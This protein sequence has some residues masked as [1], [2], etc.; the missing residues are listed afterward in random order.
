MDVEVINH[1]K[2]KIIQWDKNRYEKTGLLGSKSIHHRLML[3]A[4]ILKINETICMN[5]AF[6]K[7]IELVKALGYKVKSTD[8]SEFVKAE[9]G[10]TCMSVPFTQV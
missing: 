2:K 6:P 7:T 3:G 8:I 1:W 10:L 5:E 4:N 9:A